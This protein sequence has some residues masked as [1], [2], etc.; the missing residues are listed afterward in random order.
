MNGMCLNRLKK[1]GVFVHYNEIFLCNIIKDYNYILQIGDEVN[2]I[3]RYLCH[4]VKNL[5]K[6]VK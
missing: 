6:N 2:K 3:I 4:N 1:I 5:N